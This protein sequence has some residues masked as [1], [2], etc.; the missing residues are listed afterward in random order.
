MS[1]FCCQSHASDESNEESESD[2]KE[3]ILSDGKGMSIFSHVHVIY[4]TTITFSF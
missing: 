2:H 3:K 4:Y 1:F